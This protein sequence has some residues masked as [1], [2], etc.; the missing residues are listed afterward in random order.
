M[1]HIVFITAELTGL[2]LGIPYVP[3][4]PWI[5]PSE[6]ASSGSWW[7]QRRQ[8]RI[9]QQQA[10]AAWGMEHFMQIVR[11]LNPDLLL[12][13]IEMHPQIMATAMSPYPVALLCP[14]ISIWNRANLPPIHTGILPGKGWRGQWW[15][16]QWNWLRYGWRKR[17]ENQRDRRQQMG[18]DHMSLLH[19]YARQT[20][21]PFRARSGFTQW[22][23]PY[24]HRA[25][26]ILCLHAQEL[27]FPHNSHPSMHYLGPM[28]AESRAEKGAVSP[29]E[30]SSKPTLAAFLKPANLCVLQWAPQ[31][32]ILSQAD[33]A[34]INGGAH[35]ITECIHFG[36]P[37]LIYPLPRDDQNGNAARVVY[38]KLGIVSHPEQ[39]SPTLI[40]QHLQSLLTDPS[41]RTKV[42]QMRSQFQRYAEEKTSIRVVETLLSHSASQTDS[43]QSR[44]CKLTREEAAS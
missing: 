36:V 24:P 7:A 5:K 35:S 2:A 41:Y 14:F 20:N 12:L 22:L 23:V 39:E 21:Y 1:A 44:Q 31:L 19:C 32:Q 33:C 6:K 30:A 3:L 16:M 17:K 38:H 26:P 25:L 8:V 15:G 29:A 43:R 10:I 37:M 18:L 27:D 28:V 40:Q 34:I 9:R 4:K 11:S 13:D 42:S